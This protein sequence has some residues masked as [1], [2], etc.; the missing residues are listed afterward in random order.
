[1]HEELVGN[2]EERTREGEEDASADVSLSF[3]FLSSGACDKL[4]AHTSLCWRRFEEEARSRRPDASSGVSG[5]LP[6]HSTNTPR[7]EIILPSTYTSTV[8][9]RCDH[10]EEE[11]FG[12]SAELILLRLPP[13]DLRLVAPATSRPDARQN[14]AVLEHRRLRQLHQGRELERRVRQHV[15]GVDAS[16]DRL[17]R[18]PDTLTDLVST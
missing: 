12:V 13:L 2:R 17:V 7:L 4:S 3:A 15:D 18:T 16:G 10:A 14:L 6:Q 9:S 5:E 8:S 11:A 1:M